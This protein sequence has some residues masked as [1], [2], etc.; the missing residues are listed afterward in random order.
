MKLGDLSKEEMLKVIAH[1]FQHEINNPLTVIVG[2]TE[3]VIYRQALMSL[4]Q[5]QQILEA[6]QRIADVVKRMSQVTLEHEV[7]VQFPLP[8]LIDLQR[9]GEN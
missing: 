9:G 1:T 8:N 4:K 5:H 2:T 7:T 3:L 6:S